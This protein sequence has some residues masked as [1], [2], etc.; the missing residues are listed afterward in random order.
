MKTTV[1]WID[2]LIETKFL[3]F[4]LCLCTFFVFF[5]V[6][7]F[8]FVSWDD[9]QLLVNSDLFNPP[10]QNSLIKIWSAPQN[11]LYIPVTYSAWAAL[12]H[13]WWDESHA[14]PFLYA[15]QRFPPHPFHALNLILHIV[16]V[17]FVFS[18]LYHVLKYNFSHDIIN[19]RRIILS[20]FIG[21]SFFAFHPLQS[22]SVA[23]IAELKGMLSSFFVLIS[24]WL[25]LK[26]ISVSSDTAWRRPH[27]LAIFCF[28]LALLSKP[29]A[30]IAPFIA[31]ILGSL[32]SNLKLKQLMI[33]LA[34]WFIIAAAGAFV[35]KHAQP[36]EN[37]LYP[38]WWRPFVAGDALAFYITKTTL[39]FGLACNYA[40]TPP[41]VIE[42]WKGLVTCI[43]PLAVAVFIFCVRR[44][45]L[46]LTAALW[47]VPLLPVLG[48]VPFAYQLLSTVADR[49]AYLSL[50]GPSLMLSW[51][52]CKRQS[53]ILFLISALYC[54]LLAGL[55]YNQTR[56]WHDSE[57]LFS[58]C[59]KT[60]PRSW[61]AKEN[62]GFLAKVEGRRE[63]AITFYLQALSEPNLQPVQINDYGMT[64][65]ELQ[66]FT[67]AEISFI[68]AVKIDPTYGRAWSN[69][70][71]VY[72]FQGRFK[73]AVY[74]YE[75]AVLFLPNSAESHFNL[76]LT[77]ASLKNTKA[78]INQYQRALRIE[79]NNAEILYNLG[80][81]Y[82]NEKNYPSAQKMFLAALRS[83]PDYW[84]AWHA[85]GQIY[86]AQ[87]Q[88]AQAILTWRSLL[89]ANP[90]FQPAQQALNSL[91]RKM[92]PK[93]RNPKLL[94]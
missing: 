44:R 4:V 10:T 43:I 2:K 77:Y 65:G 68:R 1:S 53:S 13:F 49:Y 74:A 91:N 21:A 76:G 88:N 51:L 48:L 93:Q 75:K 55:C 62:L 24:V 83:K 27:Y 60:V 23:W 70:G 19:H 52:I 38:L 94:R 30:L 87:G 79:P 18:L 29:S 15:T 47:I 9:Y 63:Q 12:A 28:I 32:A 22:E 57:S 86:Y 11:Q 5:Q 66:D 61:V 92:N 85:S 46:T 84:E 45:P 59:L 41:V 54:V 72:V 56:V 82:A 26:S 35:A 14:V 58:N 73:D 3:I 17:S 7:Q 69:L 50:L 20:S 37:L 40:R 81:V 39:P 80:L 25:F 16:N 33:H 42:N 71:S 6:I 34:P 89:R 36:G 64:L 31:L 90:T 67:N 78:A 8:D